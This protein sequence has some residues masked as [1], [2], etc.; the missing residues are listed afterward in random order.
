MHNAQRSAS[1]VVLPTS[2]GGGAFGNDETWIHGAMEQ[3]FKLMSNV[4]LD[5]RLVSY[6][7]PPPAL[8]QMA[9]AFA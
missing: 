9:K 1:K 2:L 6:G 3:V 7:A 5:V 4:A 8:L